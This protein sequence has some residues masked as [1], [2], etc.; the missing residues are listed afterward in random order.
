MVVGFAGAST[1]PH[2]VGHTLSRFAASRVIECLAPEEA[3]RNTIVTDISLLKGTPCVFIVPGKSGPPV[4]TQIGHHHP[5]DRVW[6]IDLEKCPN[7]G[8]LWAPGDSLWTSTPPFNTGRMF[9]LRCKKNSP[10][11]VLQVDLPSVS[12]WSEAH[13]RVYRS[14]FPLPEKEI[15]ILRNIPERSADE[16]N[17]LLRP[18]KNLPKRKRDEADLL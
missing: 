10:T 16:L 4:A 6:G 18:R 8:C 2:V 9:C 7:K 14:V 11:I 3:L 1:I 12:R 17:R 5:P 15:E 13:P